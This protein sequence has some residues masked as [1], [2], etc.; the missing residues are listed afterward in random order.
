MS[1]LVEDVTRPDSEVQRS[2]W[3][4]EEDYELRLNCKSIHALSDVAW[5][6]AKKS[7]LSRRIIWLQSSS[8]TIAKASSSSE[9]FLILAQELVTA[10]FLEV[11]R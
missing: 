7:R 8:R 4:N 3:A 1:R 11:K 5:E 9:P 10:V 2:T 6:D